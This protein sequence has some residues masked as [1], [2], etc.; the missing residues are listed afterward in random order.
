MCRLRVLEARETLAPQNK[1]NPLR[2]WC[3][4]SG[5]GLGHA[6]QLIP[7]LNSLRTAF[8]ALEVRVRGAI[9]PQILAERLLV[10]WELD[11]VAQDV[12]LVQNDAFDVDP[13][14]TL[15]RYAEFHDSWNDRLRSEIEAIRHYDAHAVIADIPYLPFQAAAEVGIPAIGIGSLSWD[16]VLKAYAFP[17]NHRMAQ[18]LGHIRECYRSAVVMLQVQ[19]AMEM[20]TF[21]HLVPIPPIVNHGKNRSEELR[22]QLSVE[23]EQPIALVCFGGFECHRIPYQH[24]AQLGDFVFIGPNVQ[25]PAGNVFDIRDTTFAFPDLLA[26][27]DL[28]ISKPGYNLMMEAV[29]AKC[30]I[31]YV[32][33]G[34]FPDE[35]T[36]IDWI[37]HA[38]VAVEM[39]A[40]N[41][42]AGTWGPFLRAALDRADPGEA[43]LMNGAEVASQYLHD[44]ILAAA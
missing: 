29:A 25:T 9:P 30:R 2:L 14:A 3:T 15:G 18:I 39:P 17:K 7:V 4:V 28:L 6:S 16:L 24:L 40:T 26:S 5:H 27:A 42:F 20:D 32:R 38:G 31:V 43:P 37:Q 33:R 1:L 21:E 12:G 35:T 44:F 23:R 8:P 36:V 11:Q 41:F 13:A 10:P 19:P 22:A 34:H